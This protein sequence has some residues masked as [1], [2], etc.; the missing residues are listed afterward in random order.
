D[1]GH[2]T[3]LDLRPIDGH[4]SQILGRRDGEDV[5]DAEPLVRGVDPTPG[6][7][8]GAVRDVGRRTPHETA[9][10]LMI[11]SWVMPYARSRSGSTWTWSCRSRWP[12]IETF[13]TPGTPIRRGLI[14]QRAS[15]ESS[16]GESF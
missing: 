7:G 9:G 13:A 12:Q 16:I 1:L 4:A 6:S 3:E 2:V 14:V 11:C 10:G 5:L 8:E 15:T